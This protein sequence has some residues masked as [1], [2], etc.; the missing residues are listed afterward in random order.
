[1]KER[2]RQTIEVLQKHNIR[3]HAVE[4]D[5]VSIVLSDSEA[6]RVIEAL[7]EKGCAVAVDQDG[8]VFV[9]SAQ[10]HEHLKD[11]KPPV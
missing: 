4:G 7:T 5:L 8:S 10:G 6:Q 11:C 1:M 2:T 3:I 9:T